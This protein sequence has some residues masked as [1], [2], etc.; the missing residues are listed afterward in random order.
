MMFSLRTPIFRAVGITT[1]SFAKKSAKGTAAAT[2]GDN[3]NP[4]D[5]LMKRSMSLLFSF[6]D[7][8]G[9]LLQL[10][11]VKLREPGSSIKYVKT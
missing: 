11:S 1:R 2:G 5:E 6:M 3:V 9:G 4:L 8:M 7:Q 10:P